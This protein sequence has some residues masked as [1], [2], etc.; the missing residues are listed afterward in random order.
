MLKSRGEAVRGDHI[1]IFAGFPI[2]AKIGL[3]GPS[4]LKFPYE[5]GSKEISDPPL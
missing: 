3:L 1:G 4:A 5:R 2:F